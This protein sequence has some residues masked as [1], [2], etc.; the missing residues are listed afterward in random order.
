MSVEIRR[1]LEIANVGAWKMRTIERNLQDKK[2]GLRRTLY[3]SLG[4][5]LIE[6]GA[7]GLK[8]MSKW[9]SDIGEERGVYPSSASYRD[10]QL[11]F[12]ER[13][14]RFL[15]DYSKVW[16]EI[17]LESS[18]EILCGNEY[19]I[20]GMKICT[21]H[22]TATEGTLIPIIHPL[23]GVYPYVKAN[24]REGL[25]KVHRE[26]ETNVS[27]IGNHLAKLPLLLQ[28]YLEYAHVVPTISSRIQPFARRIA[29][30]LKPIQQQRNKIVLTTQLAEH[31]L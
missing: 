15:D 11:C 16:A 23:Q 19:R 24:E 22:N 30:E 28:E 2:Q 10:F 8:R 26:D 13:A 25:L 20:S 7:R 29:N 9:L 1:E 17:V 14:Q 18:E 3:Y 4:A 21:M 27:L 5:E 12:P 6:D 31:S